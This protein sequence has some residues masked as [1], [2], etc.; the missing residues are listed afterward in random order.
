MW[1]HIS[2]TLHCN[3]ARQFRVLS[4]LV[5]HADLLKVII[6]L[7]FLKNERNQ[8]VKG[9]KI[10]L[11]GFKYVLGLSMWQSTVN[12]PLGSFSYE[13]F[14]VPFFPFLRHVVIDQCQIDA[15]LLIM[16]KRSIL[17]GP[18]NEKTNFLHM[19]KEPCLCRI[20]S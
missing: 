13:F 5:F 8:K 2:R 20:W 19:R 14:S 11:T 18:S 3:I 9:R 4:L 1:Q 10:A 17:M 7:F 16:R 12:L 15:S 6:F